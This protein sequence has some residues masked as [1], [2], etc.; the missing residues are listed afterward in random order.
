MDMPT[1]Y[2]RERVLRIMA[3]QEGRPASF[4]GWLVA[5]LA[6]RRKS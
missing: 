4:W 3:R 6:R 1:D 5:L 2:R